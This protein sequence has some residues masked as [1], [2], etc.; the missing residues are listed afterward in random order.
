[1][2]SIWNTPIKNFDEFL[3]KILDRGIMFFIINDEFYFC[4]SRTM[5]FVNASERNLKGKGM[6]SAYNQYSEKRFF[7]SIGK[8]K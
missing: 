3:K 2:I 6:K 4:V 1:M 5:K 7:V 8:F